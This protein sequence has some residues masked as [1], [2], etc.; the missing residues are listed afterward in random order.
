MPEGSKKSPSSTSWCRRR[1]Q[2]PQVVRYNMTETASSAI[3]KSGRTRRRI[4]YAALN[5][6]HK[7]QELNKHPHIEQFEKFSKEQQTPLKEL[8]CLVGGVEEEEGEARSHYD[9]NGEFTDAQ[10]QKLVN[11]TKLLKPILIRGANPRVPATYNARMKVTFEIPQYGI[12]EVTAKVGP[13]RKV[14]VMDVMTQN[15]SP[16]WDMKRWCEYFLLDG[17]ARDK[18]RNVISLEI[19]DTELGGEIT[20]P[21]V[22]TD[23]DLVL[24]LFENDPALADLLESN[25]V[26]PPKVRK[27]ILMSVA[28]SYTDFHIDFAGTSVYYSPLSGHKQFILIP[29]VHRNLEAYK[30][31]C[32]SDEQNNVWF[33]SLLKPLTGRD[34]D[35]MHASGVPDAYLN[36]GFVVDILPG[37]LLLLP[38]MWIHAV[39]TKQDS[40]IIGGNFLNLLSL[41]SHLQ[42]YKIEVATRVN[43]QFK[44]PNFVK[45]VWLIAYY[46]M[47]SSSSD[48][49]PDAFQRRCFQNLVQF[50]KEQWAYVSSPKREQ[51][52]KTAVAKIKNAIPNKIIGDVAPFLRRLDVWL[53]S[54]GETE[55]PAPAVKRR[56]LQ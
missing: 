5:E 27:Y 53:A 21:K 16:R 33:P 26:F 34:K 38:S 29:P 7:I 50:L 17:P 35:R 54:L 4:D 52:E 28:G 9:E 39:Y 41:E 24:K 37:D 32:L 56:R 19:S 11:D 46:L 36:N 20:V 23:M 42:T 44:F 8:V 12:E 6:S 48:L 3:R 14:P 22:V 43:D 47:S 13:E 51:R 45:F 18:I 15:N 2:K 30:K 31:W 40:I 49:P 55:E 10:L 25:G 1:L